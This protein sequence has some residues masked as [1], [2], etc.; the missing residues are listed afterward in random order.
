MAFYDGAVLKLVHLLI[1]CYSFVWTWFSWTFKTVLS[2]GSKE[3]LSQ[4]RK[5]GRDLQKLPCHLAL[6]VQEEVI[7]YQDVCSMLVW[8]MSLGISYLSVF[9]LKGTLKKNAV[10]LKGHI[11]KLQEDL[12]GRDQYKFTY[13]LHQSHSKKHSSNEGAQV[14]I[15]LLSPSDG[16]L[17]LVQTASDYCHAVSNRMLKPTDISTDL[18]NSMLQAIK[19]FPDP[20][21]LIKFGPTESLCGYLPWQ[22]RLTEILNVQTHWRI[23]YEEFLNV[24][25]SYAKT[26]QRLGK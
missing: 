9:D 12:M 3:S 22:I 16:R 4:C 5:D 13:Q 17:D 1:S 8:S 25:H 21:L 23:D 24:L 11:D 7:S 14:H 15:A 2:K 20:D 10:L 6:L 18:V 26:E 19:G